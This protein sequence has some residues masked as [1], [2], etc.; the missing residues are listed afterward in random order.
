MTFGH[1]PNEDIDKIVQLIS[2]A[3]GAVSNHR[4]CPHCGWDLYEDNGRILHTG[5]RS[6]ECHP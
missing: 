3:D 5:T 6:T 1:F 4:A 2:P